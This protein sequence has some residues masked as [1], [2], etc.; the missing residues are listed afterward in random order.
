MRSG[1]VLRY[2]RVGKEGGI[3][4]A[5]EVLAELKRRGAVLVVKGVGL[6]VN[7]PKGTLD[8]ALLG[9]VRASKGDLL[10][11]LG[12]R[13]DR[14]ERLKE[15]WRAARRRFWAAASDAE[16]DRALG[17]LIDLSDRLFEEMGAESYWEWRD[18]QGHWLRGC[19]A[20]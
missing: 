4:T 12:E 17:E 6:V 11:L 18:R 16:A 8:D 14:V 13:A 20:E 9:A 15:R 19:D 2:D 10:R 7:A 1:K 3:M 5:T